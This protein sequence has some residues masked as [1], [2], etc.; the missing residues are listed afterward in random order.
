MAIPAFG[1]W[2]VKLPFAG[3]MKLPMMRTI[4]KSEITPPTSFAGM[5]GQNI[6]DED[7]SEKWN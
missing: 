5:L 2:K 6:A 3:P 4:L 1:A 7:G